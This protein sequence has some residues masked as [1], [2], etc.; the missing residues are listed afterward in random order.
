MVSIDHPLGDEVARHLV[1]AQ[2]EEV[3]HL[4]GE[5][6]QRDTARKTHHDGIRDVPDDGPQTEQPQQDEEHARH[7]RGDHQSALAVL[8]NDAVDNDDER[9][10][11]SANLHPAAP[12]TRHEE[13][14]DNSGDDSFLRRHARRDT[15]CDGKRQSHNADNDSRHDVGRQRSLRVAFERREELRLEFKCFHLLD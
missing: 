1:D 2:P 8:C 5:D 3:L 7:E 13:T 11:R 9:S 15:E 14:G 10:R 12:E 4:R 6:G